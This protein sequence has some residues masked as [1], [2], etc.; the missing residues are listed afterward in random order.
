RYELSI[1][2]L[3][4]EK[5]ITP[6]IKY[7]FNHPDTAISFIRQGLGIALLPELTLKA[8]AGEL[9]S[10]PLEPTFY[11]QISLLVKEAPVEGSPLFLLQMC[12]ETLVVK[13][14]L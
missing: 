4:K 7:E 13:G 8:V 10:V 6:V 2:A 3:F 5:N 11:R 14:I 12:M 1:M 9:C